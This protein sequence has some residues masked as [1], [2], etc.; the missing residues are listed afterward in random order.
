MKIKFFYVVILML[1]SMRCISQEQFLPDSTI[2]GIFVLSNSESAQIFYKDISKTHLQ[3]ENSVYN[4]FGYDFIA[5]VNKDSSQYLIAFHYD[6]DVINSYSAFEMGYVTYDFFKYVKI[7]YL[8][9]FEIF[10]TESD[11]YLNMPLDQL[12]DIKGN[13]YK[14]EDKSIIY[15][16]DIDNS[17]FVR[18]YKTH[19]Y[20]LRCE[21]DNGKVCKINFGFTYP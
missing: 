6:G 1:F 16:L 14:N 10:K 7:Y 4:P 17:D 15:Y 9:E 21:V 2:N 19:D 3:Y 11:I 18:R 13:N 8:T 5:F 20:Y 12:L